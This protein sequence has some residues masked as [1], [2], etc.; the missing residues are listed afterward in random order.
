V[1]RGQHGQCFWFT[2]RFGV[3]WQIAKRQMLRL[4][5]A[6]DRAASQRAFQEMRR[7]ISV[8]QQADEG[9]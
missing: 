1:E 2:D 5:N 9:A 6:P 8:L 3:S 4:L 7:G